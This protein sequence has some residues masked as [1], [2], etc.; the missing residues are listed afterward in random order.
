MI[1]PR[2]QPR[3]LPAALVLALVVGALSGP[4]RAQ[5]NLGQ[6]L[7]PK[8]SQGLPPEL[9]DVGIFPKMGVTVP[10]DVRLVDQNGKVVTL[11]DYILGDRPVVLVFAYYTCKM[12]CTLVLNGTMDAMKALP[13]VPGQDYRVVTVSFDGRDT[14][15]VAKEKRA[16][17]LQAFGRKI[18]PKGWDFLTGRPEEVKRLADVVGFKYR[19]VASQNQFAHAAGIFVL[20]PEGQLSRVLYGIHFPPSDLRLALTEASHGTIG[21]VTSQLLLFCFHYSPT[22]GKYVLAA[23]RVMSAGGALTVLLIGMY[24]AVHFHSEKKKRNEA[25]SS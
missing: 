5:A 16:N 25:T 14:P 12:L 1:S 6:Q 23:T 17:Y 4:A 24:L 19:W 18:G 8:S 3:L 21:S 13:L 7:D 9:K 22:K 2:P 10:K 20:T 15:A 11:G